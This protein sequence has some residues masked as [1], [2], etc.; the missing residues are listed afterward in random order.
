MSLVSVTS[1]ARLPTQTKPIN[2]GL[3]EGIGNA[4]E[5]PDGGTEITYPDG[6]RL[7]FRSTDQGYDVYFTETNGVQNYYPAG[8]PIPQAVLERF[9]QVQNT[10]TAK[11]R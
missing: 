6:S 2:L 8:A 4:A 3:I 5:L 9:K 7:S 10:V 11:F 1:V